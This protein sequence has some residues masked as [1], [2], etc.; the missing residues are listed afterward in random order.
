MQ[1][2]LEPFRKALNKLEINDPVVGV[3]SNVDGKKYKDA[4]HI[5]KQLPK[6]VLKHFYNYQIWC[7]YIFF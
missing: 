7:L 1:P 2:A 4:E 5:R 6:Q 3:Y